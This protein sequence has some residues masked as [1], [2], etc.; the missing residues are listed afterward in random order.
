MAVGRSGS[1]LRL[2]EPRRM[3]LVC[4]RQCENADLTRAEERH[5]VRVLEAGSE[6]DLP[7]ESPSRQASGKRGGCTFTTT[8]RGGGVRV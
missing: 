3:S 4:M 7:L 8:L 2:Y 5:Q 1:P 6:T